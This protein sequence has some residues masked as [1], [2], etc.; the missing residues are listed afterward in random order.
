MPNA[1]KR[2]FGCPAKHTS[3]TAFIREIEKS[4]DSGRSANETVVG[5]EKDKAKARHMKRGSREIYVLN[6]TGAHLG[7]N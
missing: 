7:C 6:K 4:R 5:V 3:V 1:A 2:P